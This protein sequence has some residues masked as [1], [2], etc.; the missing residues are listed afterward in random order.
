MKQVLKTGVLCTLMLTL[1][2]GLFAN[3]LNLNSNG[4]RALAMGGAFVALAD[5]YSAI[6]WNPAGMTQIKSHTLGF[7]FGDIIPQASYQFQLAQVDVNAETNHNFSGSLGFYKPVS[8]KVTAGIYIYVPSGT[9]VEWDGAQLAPLTGM[10]PYEWKSLFGMI[11]IS[12]AIAVKISEKFSIGASLNINYALDKVHRPAGV[13]MTPMGPVD[14]GQYEEDLS[15]L[16]VGATLGM[17]YKPSEKFSI[18]FTYKTPIK[19]KLSGEAGI[20]NAPLLGLPATSE[21]EREATWPMWIALGFCYKP[22]DAL[23]FTADAQFTNWKEMTHIP[24][25]YDH[26]AWA[27]NFEEGGKFELRWKDC[28]MLRVGMEYKV[29][30]SLALRAGYYY[31]PGPAP[32]ETHNILLPEFDYHWITLGFGYS[33]EK[34]SIDFGFEYGMGQDVTVGIDQV[35][36]RSGMPG[37]HGMNIIVPTVS[38]TYR[39]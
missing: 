13:A 9:S 25:A 17:L 36:N 20:S 30:E 33:T 24:I 21:G 34:M 1:A 2:L 12:P 3:G 35:D 26:P 22:T 23:T 14:L 27:Q 10:T 29:S 15:G 38:F 31:D 37:T 11:T 32:I 6:Y 19:A 4:S 5:D 28:I 7:Y 18:G 39:F 8:D 16:A